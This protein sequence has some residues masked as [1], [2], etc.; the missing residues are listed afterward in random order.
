MNRV[1]PHLRAI[2]VERLSVGEPVDG[3]AEHLAS[4]PVCTEQVERLKA[5]ARAFVDRRPATLVVPRI[6]ARGRPSPWWQRWWWL[7]VPAAVTAS[8]AL[9]LAPSSPSEVRLKGSGLSVLVNGST[10]VG[11][12]SE[13]AAGDQLSFV[14]ETSKPMHALVLGLEE[15]R[16]A[17]AF[18]P[19]GGRHSIVV[20]AGRAV[21]GDAVALDATTRREW[22][23]WLLCDSPFS[24]DDLALPDVGTSARP[25]V[26][27][28][29][30]TVQTLEVTR[31]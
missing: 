24:I 29:G 9:M 30:C 28:P 12:D 10:P 31:R 15:G 2:D 13:F 6:R 26:E 16:P 17:M 14:V 21:L 19:F 27:R 8:F 22:L 5:Q 23:V 11:P 4:C 3:V 7:S 20:P 18:A 25:V 1:H